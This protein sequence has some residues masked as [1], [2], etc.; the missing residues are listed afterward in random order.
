MIQ[1]VQTIYLL[2]ATLLSAFQ[3]VWSFRHCDW[4]GLGFAVAACLIALISIFL[5]KNRKRQAG[6]VIALAIIAVLA[7]AEAVTAAF[8]QKSAFDLDFWYYTGQ[9]VIVFLLATAAYRAIRK[10]EKLVR[11]LDRIR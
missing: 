5:Y 11:S 4:T 1:R 7:V 2:F 10:D 6:F 8:I 9:A 3:S